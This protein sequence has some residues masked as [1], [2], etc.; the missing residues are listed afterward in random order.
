ML[1][2]FFLFLFIVCCD[3]DALRGFWPGMILFVLTRRTVK[4]LEVSDK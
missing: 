3:E 2:L 4:G 1:V